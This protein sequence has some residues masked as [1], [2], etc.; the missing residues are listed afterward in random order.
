MTIVLVTLGTLLNLFKPSNLRN[1]I[2][3]VIQP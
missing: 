2:T 3:Q 1:L